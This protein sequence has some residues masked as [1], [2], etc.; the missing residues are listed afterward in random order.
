MGFAAALNSQ[1]CRPHRAQLKAVRQGGC[2]VPM[3]DM[4]SVRGRVVG[5]KPTGPSNESSGR[6]KIAAIGRPVL[7]IVTTRM[8]VRP[9]G[10]GP[11]V[12][13]TVHARLVVP[14]THCIARLQIGHARERC[15]HRA[16]HAAEEVVAHSPL[17][18]GCSR[19]GRSRG[20]RR[21]P[22]RAC[23]ASQ[24]LLT[25]SPA[26]PHSTCLPPLRGDR[27]SGDDL[28]LNVCGGGSSVSRSEADLDRRIPKES[29]RPING[30]GVLWFLQ[31]SLPP[32]GPALRAA[33]MRPAAAR[34]R[35]AACARC[36]R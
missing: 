30:P 9:R 27:T 34:S 23:P 11:S 31:S 26:L 29:T 24:Q 5:A 28:R 22:R 21:K 16:I 19:G 8:A 13:A 1:R 12:S 17:P 3:F 32:C 2:P 33:G 14:N 15:A 20:R 6:Q 18:Q 25:P 36:A 4:L 10:C 35:P 7:V